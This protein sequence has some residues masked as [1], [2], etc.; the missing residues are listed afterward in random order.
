MADSSDGGDGVPFEGVEI[1]CFNLVSKL[2]SLPRC[3]IRIQ[4]WTTR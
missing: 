3:D 1:C 4:F 2:I